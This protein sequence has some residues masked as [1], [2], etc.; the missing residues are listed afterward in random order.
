[1][2][3]HADIFPEQNGAERAGELLDLSRGVVIASGAVRRGDRVDEAK[4]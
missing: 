1:V 4:R 3:R 2:K